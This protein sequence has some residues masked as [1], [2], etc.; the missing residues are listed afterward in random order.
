[1]TLTD[2]DYENMA[3]ACTECVNSGISKV[4]VD[5]GNIAIILTVDV[6]MEG[7]REDDYYNGTGYF[8]PTAAAC[9]VIDIEYDI[10][11]DDIELPVVDKSR[12]EE[13]TYKIL[14]QF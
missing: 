11:E 10:C 7:Y 1:M 4:S 9:R 5:K 8:I 12:I 6:E 2:K 3:V 14:M 13:L